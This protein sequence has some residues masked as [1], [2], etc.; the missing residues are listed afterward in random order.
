MAKTQDYE[1]EQ[2]LKNRMKLNK[3]LS[4]KL[5]N[6][7]EYDR[8]IQVLDEK[9]DQIVNRILEELNVPNISQQT[10]LEKTINVEENKM[11]EEVKEQKKEKI[12]VA[13]IIVDVLQLKTIRNEDNAVKKIME[14]I[15]NSNEKK[16]R[17]R[18]KRVISLVSKKTGKWAKYTFDTNTYLLTINQ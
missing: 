2:M 1:L 15:P 17:A 5:I 10:N 6:Q 3:L 11:V 9:K 8:Q 14:K 7:S 16:I 4:E 12:N 13:K 18:I